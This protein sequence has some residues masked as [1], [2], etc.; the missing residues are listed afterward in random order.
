MDSTHIDILMAAFANN[1]NV[2]NQLKDHTSRDPARS[3]ETVDYLQ[4][5]FDKLREKIKNNKPLTN[6][7]CTMI[8]TMLQTI[9]SALRKQ[10]RI[11]AESIYIYDSLREHYVAAA[12]LL[13][14]EERR[15]YLDTNQLTVAG[16]GELRGKFMSD[17]EMTMSKIF[18][19]M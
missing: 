11:A 2:L 17:K 6:A 4:G 7:D 18:D 1:E 3:T 8:A 14:D 19:R 12:R 10:I 15:Q 13:S 16:V 9:D 5:V